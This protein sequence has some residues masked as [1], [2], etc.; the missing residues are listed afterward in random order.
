M[1]ERSPKK[2]KR[3]RTHAQKRYKTGS[4]LYCNK[5]TSRD[6]YSGTM[7]AFAH[8]PAKWRSRCNVRA[9]SPHPWAHLL[10]SLVPLC[11]P[12]RSHPEPHFISGSITTGSRFLLITKSFSSNCVALSPSHDK[13]TEETKAM[14]LIEMCEHTKNNFHWEVSWANALP[15]IKLFRREKSVQ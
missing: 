10:D 15:P 5:F 2:K 3:K 13:P 8:A 7:H 1:N 14:L 9:R 11:L 12:S 4:S 6:L